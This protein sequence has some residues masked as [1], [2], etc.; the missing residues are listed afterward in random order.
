[1]QRK[2]GFLGLMLALALGCSSSGTTG[3]TVSGSGNNSGNPGGGGNGGNTGNGGSGTNPGV[4]AACGTKTFGLQ[5]VPPD[6]MIV[7]DK[8]G[9]MDDLP[10]GTNCNRRSMANCATDAKWPLMTAA[11]NQVVMQTQDSIRWGLKYFPDQFLDQCGVVAAPEVPIAP[12]NAAAIARS[13]LLT[14]PNG[15]TPTRAAVAAASLN[16]AMLMDP[17]PKFLLL[18]TDGQPNCAPNGGSGSDDAAG[19]IQAVKDSAMMGI[20][21]FV[22]GI[23]SVPDA[24]TTLTA[25]A[26]AGGRPQAADPKYYPVA[27]TAEL[28]SVLGTI[29]GMIG[30]CSFGLGAVPPDP[31]NIAVTSNGNKIPKDTGHTNG[32]DYGTGQT[33]VQLF[34][35]WCDDAKAGK[36]TDVKAIFGCP[37]KVIP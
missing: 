9:S 24:Q 3:V 33:S 34:G 1:M 26:E 22:V 29:G 31:T 27:N 13:I 35:M 16:A 8:S 11:I 7:L 17:N 18:A 32:W 15:G 25:M 5:K 4:G 12:M 23:G 20:P 37:G 2:I 30:S 28:V 6:L 14:R 10:D 19:A 36:L 21:V